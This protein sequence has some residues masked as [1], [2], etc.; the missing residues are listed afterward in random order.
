[1]KEK[2]IQEVMALVD[3]LAGVKHSQGMDD[4]SDFPDRRRD[5]RERQKEADELRAAIESALREQ[6]RE[7]PE[8][9]KLVPVEPTIEMLDSVYSFEVEV[10]LGGTQTLFPTEY[11]EIYQRM[12][13]TAPTQPAQAEQPKAATQWPIS[14]D[15]AAELERSDWTPEEALR[16]Y[17]AGRHYDTVPNGDGTSSARILDNGAVASNALKSMSVEYAMHKGDV[18]LLEQPKKSDC[19]ECANADSW[20]LPDKAFCAGCFG[21]SHWSPLNRSSVNPNVK[22]SQP[23]AAQQE[24]VAWL[25]CGVGSGRPI[26]VAFSSEQV[27]A[28]DDHCEL[29]PLYTAAAPQREPM[30]NGA[31]ASEIEHLAD[32]LGWALDPQEVIDLVHFVNEFLALRAHGI[33]KKEQQEPVYQVQG[34]DGRWTDQ[35]KASYDYNSKH[36]SNRVRVLYTAAPQ[37]EPMTDEQIEAGAIEA[38]Y[39]KYKMSAFFEGALY[40]ERFHGIT[41]KEQQ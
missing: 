18:A 27:R 30:A 19:T 23:K 33:T 38:G 28:M 3:E 10:D 35:T 16:W 5:S 31:T 29:V 8:G 41:K 13:S 12:L 36:P 6:V 20:G 22:V 9:W 15:V 4:N 25:G 26:A 39:N 1:M 21:G 7:V 14:P 40:A 2:Q 37:R 17:A 32:K 11:L 24:P 34:A